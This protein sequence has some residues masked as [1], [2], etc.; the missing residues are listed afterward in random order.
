MWIEKRRP[1][2]FSRKARG[3]GN[4]LRK[5]YSINGKIVWA[6]KN[7]H[8]LKAQKML[9]ERRLVVAAAFAGFV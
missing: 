4:I 7:I 3:K 6:L 1:A 2:S 9:V 5:V 8:R